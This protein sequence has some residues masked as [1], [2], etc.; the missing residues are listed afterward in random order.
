MQCVSFQT[1][2]KTSRE[3]E[4]NFQIFRNF[5]LHSA[6][7]FMHDLEFP[8]EIKRNKYMMANK[9]SYKK[10]THYTT[11]HFL[12]I[13]LFLKYGCHRVIFR[14]DGYQKSKTDKIYSKEKRY[15]I[16]SAC[17]FVLWKVVRHSRA[18]LLFYNIAKWR[19]SIMVNYINQKQ[20]LHSFNLNVK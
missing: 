20:K 9:K 18:S 14:R 15:V 4:S 2:E 10:R 8:S 19:C 7:V 16:N 3:S 13:H 11:R 1:S 12:I 17:L 6:Q 5:I